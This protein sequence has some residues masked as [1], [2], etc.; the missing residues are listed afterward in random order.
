MGIWFF[1]ELEQMVLMVRMKKS[2]VD[3]WRDRRTNIPL[4]ENTK[5]VRK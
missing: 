3:W 5:H 1:I 2:I 4:V